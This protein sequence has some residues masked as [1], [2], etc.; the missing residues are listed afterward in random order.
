MSEGHLKRNIVVKTVEMRDGEV[1]GADLRFWPVRLW[2]PQ[3]FLSRGSGRKPGLSRTMFLI[4]H[5]SSLG[6]LWERRRSP[7]VI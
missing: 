5:K 4:T 1:R 6:S 3:E 7:D 2:L